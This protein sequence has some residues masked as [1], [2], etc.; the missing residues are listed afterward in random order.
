M[1]NN[2]KSAMSS[3]YH[4]GRAENADDGF[5]KLGAIVVIKGP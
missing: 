1:A 3:T 4:S 5:S 2:K